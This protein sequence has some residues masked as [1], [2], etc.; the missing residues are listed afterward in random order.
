MRSL[1]ENAVHVREV[2]MTDVRSG[3]APTT[4]GTQ[5]SRRTLITGVAWSAPVIM[6]VA[7]TPAASASTGAPT[8]PPP[9]P[10]SIIFYDAGVD[11]LWAPGNMKT[12]LK[13]RIKVGNQYASNGATLSVL[14]VTVKVPRSHFIGGGSPSIATASLPE[15][16]GTGSW[17]LSGYSDDGVQYIT[18]SLTFTGRLTSEASANT[19][20][21]HLSLTATHDIKTTI[22]STVTAASTP[23][24]TNSPISATATA[25]VY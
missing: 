4:A 24:V 14:I 22:S 25:T 1:S 15:N 20:L 16:G 2:E 10:G 19:G 5:S 13:F 17:S 7:A 12:G 3:S 11:F 21:V 18:Y 6:S 23:Q 8:A 9:Q